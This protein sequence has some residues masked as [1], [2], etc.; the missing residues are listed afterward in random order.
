MTCALLVLEQPWMP[1]GEDPLQ[2]SL[3]PLLRSLNNLTPMPVFF[4]QFYD[5]LS[6]DLAL[7]HLLTVSRLDH[8]T[9]VILY[10]AS[11]GKGR[12]LYSTLGDS[13]ELNILFNSIAQ[14]SDE[15]IT[16]LILDACHVGQADSEIQA[17]LPDASLQ[18]VLA[19]RRSVSFIATTLI[20][21]NL[22]H[23]LS[24]LTRR[25]VFKP[26]TLQRAFQKGFSA[27]NPY[28][29]MA[30]QGKKADEVLD[31]ALHETLCLYLANP[32]EGGC[33]AL[34]SDLIWD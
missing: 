13:I 9:H 25:D 1:V 29:L 7:K 28:W 14:N 5:D 32:K 22:L 10:V 20:H 16:G 11:H 31:K 2:T 34:T 30:S 12:K 4:A 27:F 3:E 24:T 33:S 15:L 19:Y 26:K 6:F 18:W 17:Y 21:L 23:S 8:I